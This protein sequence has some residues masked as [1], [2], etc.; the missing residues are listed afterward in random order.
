MGDHGFDLYL[1]GHVHAMQHYSLN[2]KGTF[3]TSGAGSMVHTQ[4]QQND[5]HCAAT[6]RDFKE[7]S[8]PAVK[9]ES[10][11]KMIWNTKA[12]GF[13][14]HTFNEDFA[15]LTTQFVSVSGDVV[16]SFDVQKGGGPAPSP[17]PGRQCDNSK[18]PCSDGCT[19]IH[20][21]N[22]GTCKVSKYGCYDCSALS[23][24]CPDCQSAAS[25]EVIV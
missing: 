16:H 15:T 25:A 6:D 20:A 2:E 13:T 14:L 5:Q 11:F 22:Q 17:G 3:V 7:E 18:Y 12:A 21:K 9:G 23:S 10:N 4:D 8:F 24:D 1:N 19:Y